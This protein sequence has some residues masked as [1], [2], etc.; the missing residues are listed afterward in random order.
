MKNNRQHPH[1]F[2][3]HLWLTLALFLCVIVAFFFYLRTGSRL[4][5]AYEERFTAI[6]LADELRQSSDDLSRMVRTYVVT[7]NPVYKQWMQEVLDIRDGKQPRPID[8]SNVYWDLVLENNLRPSGF[9]DAAPLLKL[10]WDAGVSSAEFTKLLESKEKSDR[11]TYTEYAAMALIE[12]AEADAQAHAKAI[13][14]LHDTAYHQAKLEIM[15]PLREF[16]QMVD[17]RT[18]AQIQGLEAHLNLL[19]WLLTLTGTLL[20]ALLWNA[21]RTLHRILGSSLEA[22]YSRIELL[23][24]GNFS[25]PMPPDARLDNTVIGKLNETQQQLQQLDCRRA[26][27]ESALRDSE[28]RFHDIAEASGDWIW[29]VDNGLRFVY[30]SDSVQM[31]FGYQASELI[32]KQLFKFMPPEEH[33]R[34]SKAVIPLLQRKACF[35]DLEVA[36]LDHAGHLHHIVCNANPI[37]SKEGHLLGYRGVIRD[38]TARKQAEIDLRIAATAFDSGEGMVITD[39]QGLILRVNQAFLNDSG[40][41]RNELNGYR[42]GMAKTDTLDER[43]YHEMWKQIRTNGC[44]QGEVMDRRKNG[45]SY[46]KWLSVSAVKD[47]QGVVTHYIS[48]HFDLTE[49]K[50]VEDRVFELAYFDQITGLPNR[51]LFLD[52]L[53]QSMAAASRNG[54]YG[55][56]FFIDL[57]NFK[58]L[59]DTLGHD[60]GDQLLKVVGQRLAASVRRENTVARLGGDEFVLVIQNLSSSESVAAKFAEGIAEKILKVLNR[61]Y[62]LANTSHHSSQSIGIT[63]FQGES[64]PVDKLMRQADLAMYKAKSSGRNA[65]RFFDPDMETS[66]AQR[67]ALEKDL[68][69]GISKEQF[70]LYYQAQIN[71][72]GIFDGSEA[73]LRWQHPERGMV[74]PA[75]FIPL[76]EDSDLILPLGQWIMECAC[77]Q[78]L[79]WARYPELEPLSLSVNVS[80][81][82]F[83]E[84]DFVS[85]VLAAL[86]TSG[87]NPKRLKLELTESLLVDKVDEIIEKMLALKAVGVSFSLDDF[88]TGY[89]SLAYL[90]RLPL[91]QLKIDRSFV[92]DIHEDQ[93]AAS[94]VKTIL[95]LGNSLGISVIAEGVETQEQWDFLQGAGCLAGQGY[96]FS[97]PL[98]AQQFIEL[99]RQQAAHR[100]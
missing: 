48:T 1:S 96:L 7:R 13:T 89:S 72:Q 98:P 21:K 39:H 49:R 93:N 74:P 56:L 91:D 80:A 22:L 68:R 37:I 42:M 50:K 88:G 23:G 15:R 44:W 27:S 4:E 35:R 76:A 94:I 92:H 52:R 62:T 20:I 30:V 57:D 17:A 33:R 46:P 70:T 100:E 61:P 34:V 58:T 2:F 97:Q 9:A 71:E 29:E 6:R 65:F 69:E 32:G 24:S 12:S 43:F 10:L 45:Q 5:R 41:T 54:M 66:V 16:E 59:N 40:Y 55:A 79:D 63:L 64:T 85:K 99:I 18:Q 8:Y 86:Q 19:R 73:L 82:Q 60:I 11:L 14:M 77:K 53:K 26:Q 38:I 67:A 87:A 84:K 75:D 3:L 36:M 51:M 25:E 31:Q 95:A 47:S 83:H 28:Q 90:R 81:R 78:L